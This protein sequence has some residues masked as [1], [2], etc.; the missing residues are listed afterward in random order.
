MTLED[1]PG[2]IL[3]KARSMTGVTPETAAELL[4]IAPAA[5]AQIESTGHL[6]AGLA[7]APLA[8]RL[9]LDAARLQALARGWVP[10][11]PNLAR[12]QNLSRLVT[13]HEDYEVNSYLI[14]DEATR[15]AALFD[16]GWNARE[17]RRLVA[18]HALRLESLFITHSHRDHVAA[19]G[20][21]TGAFP[22]L[23]VRRNPVAAAIGKLQVSARPTAGH[24]EDGVTW[25]IEGWPGAAPAVAIVGD[26]VFAG[27]I[28]RGFH[29]WHEARR[30]VREQIFTLPAT[31]L[32]CP[33]H[34]PLTTVA[35][36]LAH[37][38]F[39]PSSAPA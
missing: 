12:W 20:D 21:L 31:T 25:I 1:H 27:S 11:R 23:C 37:N 6:P 9:E 4:G 14:W 35:E 10:Q 32:L 19:L 2:D 22:D 38:P 30:S 5:Y 15:A 36:E 29:S 17:A 33:G 13:A 34:G 3:A 7:L 18:S 24:A 28:G 39:F 16:T 26:A 8:R